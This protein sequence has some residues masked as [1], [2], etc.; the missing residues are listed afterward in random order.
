MCTLTL[1]VPILCCCTPWPQCVGRIYRANT[2][3]KWIN[4]CRW[5]VCDDDRTRWRAQGRSV[6]VRPLSGPPVKATIAE[7]VLGDDVR[8]RV[9]KTHSH[10]SGE[11]TIITIGLMTRF[12]FCLPIVDLCSY[13]F[14]TFNTDVY[15][16]IQII[17]T[18]SRLCGTSTCDS[19]KKCMRKMPPHFTHSHRMSMY[20]GQNDYQYRINVLSTKIKLSL[21]ESSKSYKN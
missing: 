11:R 9:G 2:L 17:Q 15:K 13:L 12:I 10:G 21:D 1:K 7:V 20:N 8:T 6:A 3:I 18:F 4:D 16:P 5:D 19:F 14:Y